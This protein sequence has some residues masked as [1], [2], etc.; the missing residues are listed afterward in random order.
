[1]ARLLKLMVQGTG[2]RVRVA[3]TADQALSII[4]SCGDHID[5]LIAELSLVHLSG[6]RVAAFA[7]ERKAGLP[8]VLLCNVAPR[9]IQTGAVFLR[10]PFTHRQLLQAIRR[11]QMKGIK[12][13]EH[14]LETLAPSSQL[15][16][17]PGPDDPTGSNDRR[18]ERS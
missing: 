10:T 15:P 18:R 1:M 4:E 14:H 3:V 16:L 8:V 7:V 17:S 9:G 5:L 2:F 6:M 12:T 13:L 11:S